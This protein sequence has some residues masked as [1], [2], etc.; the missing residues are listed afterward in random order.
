[1]ARSLARFDSGT[2]EAPLGIEMAIL[3]EKPSDLE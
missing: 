2:L 1:M 3:G